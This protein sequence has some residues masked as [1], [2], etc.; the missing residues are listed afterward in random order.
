L[1]IIEHTPANHD[2][3]RAEKP[4]FRYR[5]R[6]GKTGPLRYCSLL[7]L[8]RVW[9]RAFRRACVP[10]VY[11]RGFNPRPKLQIAAGLPL[12]Y[13][14]TCE[15]LDIWLEHDLPQPAQALSRLQ[16]LCPPGLSVQSL[17]PAD[18]R[19]PALQTL[20]RLA[21]YQVSLDDTVNRTAL[22]EHLQA[23]LS[24]KQIVRER[25]G[26]TYDLRPLVKAIDIVPEDPLTLRMVLAL[27]QDQGTGRPDMILEALG[28]DPLSARVTRTAIE[29]E[30]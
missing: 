4:Q 29:F 19:G 13:S 14:S 26:K 3:P 24:Q 6:F 2:A 11:S 16:L 30:A 21:S 25:R 27:S 18:I 23:F 28:L 1:S 8:M 17:E 10:L 5:I 9:E 12:G 7:D 15:V 22:V 20:T